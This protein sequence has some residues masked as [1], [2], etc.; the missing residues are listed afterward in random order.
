[1]IKR[2][3]RL[4]EDWLSTRNKGQIIEAKHILSD[5]KIVN[6]TNL[7]DK[8]GEDGKFLDSIFQENWEQYGKTKG[9]ARKSIVKKLNGLFEMQDGSVVKEIGQSY[10]PI[11]DRSNQ[12]QSKIEPNERDIV[13]QIR[14]AIISGNMSIALELIKSSWANLSLNDRNSLIEFVNRIN[15]YNSEASDVPKGKGVKIKPLEKKSDMTKDEFAE[16]ITM[17]AIEN[18]KIQ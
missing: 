14:H 3:V 17:T 8:M 15:L 6:Y 12:M 1:M 4:F 18:M 7:I 11:T 5:S 16:K 9:E 10:M 2:I 13:I